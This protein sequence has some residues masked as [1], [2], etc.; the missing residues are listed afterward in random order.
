MELTRAQKTKKQ[1]GQCITPFCRN[2]ARKCRAICNTCKSRKQREKYPVKALWWNLR[3]HS[4]AR[5]HSCTIP[6]ADFEAFVLANGYAT[7]HGRAGN[8]L[9]I[10]R[11]DPTKG[12]DDLENLRVLTNSDNVRMYHAML[13]LAKKYGWPTA[14]ERVNEDVDEPF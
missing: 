7:G 5:G 1:T 6:Y 4:K 9:T 8:A 13:A 2:R 10:D 3:T 11:I 12:Y 14:V